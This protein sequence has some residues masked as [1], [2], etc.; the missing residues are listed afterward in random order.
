MEDLK[1]ILS[2][3]L[4]VNIDNI[5]ED[6]SRDNVESWDSFNHILL[7]TEIENTIGVEFTAIEVEQARTYNHLKDIISRKR[8]I[9]DNN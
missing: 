2:K 7:I 8:Q 3:V 5:N 4:N 6:L 9:E 1:V